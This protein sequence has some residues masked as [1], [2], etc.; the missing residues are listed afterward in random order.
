MA[1]NDELVSV[2]VPR[3]HLTNVYRF[4]ASLDDETHA[5][6]NGE[7]LEGREWT[8]ELVERQFNESPD[9]VQRLQK[10]LAEHPDQEFSTWDLQKKLQVKNANSMPGIFGAFGKR[11]KMRY[12]MPT[13][14]FTARWDEAKN[15]MFYSMPVDRAKILK[16][17]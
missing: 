12:G 1:S 5:K 15:S 9:V 3:Q 14:P 13:W 7:S 2:L 16:G 6:P 11:V 4:V 10:L 17:L 8:R